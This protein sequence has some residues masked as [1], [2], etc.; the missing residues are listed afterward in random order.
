MHS[1]VRS[2]TGVRN[3][4]TLPLS[5]FFFILFFQKHIF[6]LSEANVL[7]IEIEICHRR[8]HSHCFECDSFN[9]A[10]KTKQKKILGTRS[11]LSFW[12]F[13][14]FFFLLRK[15][16][17]CPWESRIPKFQQ[18][19]KIKKKMN[20]QRWQTTRHRRPFQRK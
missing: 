11:F 18:H 8:F 16:Q 9:S 17:N 2:F 4:F 19:K 12:I 10:S 1:N 5:Y 7:H 13:R 15:E 3:D 14:C 20:S 6:I